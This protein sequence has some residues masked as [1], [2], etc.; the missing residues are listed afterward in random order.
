MVATWYLESC[1]SSSNVVNGGYTC[2][3]AKAA[4]RLPA[5]EAANTITINC[6]VMIMIRCVGCF[7]SRGEPAKKIETVVM[8]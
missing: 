1:K 7:V 5:K 4:T 2:R 3:V 6:T 8:K